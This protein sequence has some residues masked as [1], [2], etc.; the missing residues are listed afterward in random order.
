MDKIEKYS[1]YIIEFLEEE[2]TYKIANLAETVNTQVVADTQRHHYQL[3][4][5][6]WNKR[7]FVFYCVYHFDI[8]NGK[9]WIQQNNTEVM[10]ADK[11]ME[12]GVMKS[13]IVLGFVSEFFRA[14]SGFA[15]A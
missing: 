9:I 11:L 15:V 2:A 10:V 8:R 6:G 14:S 7:E 13:D 4:R 3:L 12:K 1:Q 5:V